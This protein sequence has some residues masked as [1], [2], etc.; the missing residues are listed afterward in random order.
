MK[1]TDIASLLATE[2]WLSNRV[3]A[4]AVNVMITAIED[5]LKKWEEVSINSFW[6]FTVQTSKA[7]DWVN[8]KTWEKIKIA[9]KKRVKFKASS[10]LNKEM[11]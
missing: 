2:L 10:S 7:R 8:P 1:K 5:T 3:A 11:N 9:S 4:D 6:K